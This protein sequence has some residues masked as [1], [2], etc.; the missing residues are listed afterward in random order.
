MKK[1]K[2]LISACL[3]GHKVKYDG[4]DNKIDTVMLSRYF[5]LIPCCPEVSGGLSTPRPPSEIL[6][7][8]PWQLVD[9]DG[10][11]VTGAFVRGAEDAWRLCEDEGICFALLKSNSPSC[12]S[13]QVHD[14]TFS[15]KLIKGRGVTAALLEC[16]GV[17]VYDET[18]LEELFATEAIGGDRMP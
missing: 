4:G 15:G 13:R 18:M 6:H 12:G 9:I 3:L 1:P 7:R 10:E 8:N 17:R 14:G 16:R 2:L 5:E 11:D